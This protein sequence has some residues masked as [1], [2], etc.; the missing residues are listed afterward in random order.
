MMRLCHDPWGRGQPPHMLA[1][2]TELSSQAW[3]GKSL[4]LS[5]SVSPLL[6]TLCHRRR[7]QCKS[8]HDTG[9]PL[10]FRIY[11]VQLENASSVLNKASHQSKSLNYVPVKQNIRNRE[12]IHT[13]F[14]GVHLEYK[15]PQPPLRVLSSSVWIILKPF[16]FSI[17]ER[18]GLGYAPI[19]LWFCLILSLKIYCGLT[20]GSR[21]TLKVDFGSID[22][23]SSS[24]WSHPLCLC[25]PSTMETGWVT[26]ST[27]SLTPPLT[28]FPPGSLSWT[29]LLGKGEEASC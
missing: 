25:D 5:C 24:K 29:T 3:C 16:F 4:S 12:Y 21:M 11:W 19:M 20:W 13:L 26:M 22:L 17:L 2:G 15:S 10:L 8:I 9:K 18:H 27:F 28:T 23:T 6:L 14:I 7:K 1:S